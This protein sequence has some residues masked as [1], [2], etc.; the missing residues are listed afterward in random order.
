[1][2]RTGE[3]RS[4]RTAVRL[5]DGTY[6]GPLGVVD[7][8]VGEG[9]LHHAL[10]E[11]SEVDKT[12]RHPEAPLGDLL[13]RTGAQR[14][15]QRRLRCRAHDAFVVEETDHFVEPRFLSYP[16]PNA[17]NP[18]LGLGARSNICSTM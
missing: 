1:M 3:T 14:V 15:V 13:P 18:G 11:I 7:T 2:H 6:R 5:E 8:V 16:V 4:I 10:L 12:Y 9:G 17:S